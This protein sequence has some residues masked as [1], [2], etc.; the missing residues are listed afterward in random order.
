MTRPHQVAVDLGPELHCKLE[1]AEKAF[2]L[3]RSS[4]L[5]A[6][7]DHGLQCNAIIEY[8]SNK[9]EESSK[10][11]KGIQSYKSTTR[12]KGSWGLTEDDWDVINLFRKVYRIPTHAK[13]SW[14]AISKV[15]KARRREGISQDEL[16]EMVKKSPQ[17]QLI[18]STLQRGGKPT[19]SGMFSEKMVGQLLT[20]TWDAPKEFMGMTKSEL[21]NYKTD[22]MMK[23]IGSVK[24]WL[25]DKFC[26]E[27]DG[28]ENK[29]AVD[30]LVKEYT[31]G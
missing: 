11:K 10:D 17:H 27:M 25:R 2:G 6:L 4:L 23:H 1:K 5:R 26:L 12:K 29:D 8:F 28:A 16:L 19:L 21:E 22:M 30:A 15:L 7:I 31:G 24:R 18:A 9:G 13:M 14:P 3:S 20:L